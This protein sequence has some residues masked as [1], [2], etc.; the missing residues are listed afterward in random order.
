[1][2]PATTHASRV[3]SDSTIETT[4]A[5]EEPAAQE[6]VVTATSCEE[7]VLLGAWLRLGVHVNAIGSNFLFELEVDQDV[8]RRVTF[9]CIHPCKELRTEAEDLL[10]DI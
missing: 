7:P 4:S 1:L 8:V 3:R 6:I 9:V 2:A 5:P 10:C